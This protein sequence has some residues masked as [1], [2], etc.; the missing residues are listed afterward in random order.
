MQKSGV[1]AVGMVIGLIAVVVI[2]I[3]YTN[4]VVDR[5]LKQANLTLKTAIAEQELVVATVADLV[6]QSGA[7]EVTEKIVVD[8]SATERQKF[9]TLLDKLSASISKP[10]LTELDSLFFRCGSFYADRKGVMAARLIREVSVYRDYIELRAEIISG[11]EELLKRVV[12]WQ[13]VAESELLLASDFDKLVELQRDIIMTL[14]AG[15]DRTSPEI[16]S[17]LEHVALVKNNMTVLTKQVENA[18]AE[19]RTI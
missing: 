19:L 18:R 17:T 6:R 3:T 14:L 7:D 5:E 12:Y 11:D 8:C 4:S 15:K 13:Q 2:A 10:E 9:E 1:Y 16:S